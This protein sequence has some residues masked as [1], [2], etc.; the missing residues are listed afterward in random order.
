MKMS[1]F[2]FLVLSKDDMIPREILQSMLHLRQVVQVLIENFRKHPKL[3]CQ[4]PVIVR[5]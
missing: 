5:R 2:G 3:R 1:K 4:R